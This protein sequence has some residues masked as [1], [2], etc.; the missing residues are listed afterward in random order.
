ME[1]LMGETKV[2]LSL[3][4]SMGVEG[5]SEPLGKSG[6]SDRRWV[7]TTLEGRQHHF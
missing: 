7:G 5:H 6:A 2:P 1:Q 4:L 3:G